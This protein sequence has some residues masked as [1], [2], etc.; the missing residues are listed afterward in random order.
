[1]DEPPPVERGVNRLVVGW[2]YFGG[3]WPRRLQRAREKEV[4]DEEKR[5]A[6]K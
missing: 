1:M 2:S 4:S 5:R 3:S 6:R